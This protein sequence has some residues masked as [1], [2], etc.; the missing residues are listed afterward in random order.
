M[1]LSLRPAT[2]NDQQKIIALI[3]KVRINPRN[4][5]WER[6]IIAEDNGV[7]VGCGQIKPH[8]DGTKELASIAVEPEY[9]GKGVGTLIMNALLEREPGELYLTCL[10][11]NV[12]YYEK[13]GF[14]ELKFEEFPPDMKRM[15]RFARVVL[16]VFW[17]EGCV[18]RRN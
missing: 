8:G 18:M 1:S 15:F 2:I 11:H 6:F 13:F 16:W 14:R 17:V 4:L 3:N 12:T 5:N 9:Q 10:R 7:M